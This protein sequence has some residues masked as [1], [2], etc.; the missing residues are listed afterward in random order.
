MQK[1][2]PVCMK[3]RKSFLIHQS[4]VLFLV[5]DDLYLLFP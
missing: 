3:K 4:Q 5:H 1:G 2:G